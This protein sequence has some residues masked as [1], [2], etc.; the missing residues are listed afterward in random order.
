M[1]ENDKTMEKYPF[2]MLM[3]NG[4]SFSFSYIMPFVFVCFGLYVS[5]SFSELCIVLLMYLEKKYHEG[6]VI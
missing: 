6:T 4:F 5:Y 2:M 1:I 3:Q